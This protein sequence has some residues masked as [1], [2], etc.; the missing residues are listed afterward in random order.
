MA[1]AK[2]SEDVMNAL[3]ENTKVIDANTQVLVSMSEDKDKKETKE[4][5]V[6]PKKQVNSS[7][8]SDEKTRYANIGKELFAPVLK[9]LEKLLK[10]EKK[11]NEMTISNESETVEKA[12][13]VQYE[14]KPKEDN[15]KRTS[16]I[17]IL[18]GILAVAGIAV[19]MF[20]DKIV[21]FFDNAWSWIKDTFGTIAKFFDFSNP[22]NPISKIL[23]AIGT[24][25]SVTWDLVKKAFS[26]LGKLG[27]VIWDGIK[28]AW[29]K[30][31]TGPDGILNFGVKII[32]GIIDFAKSAVSWI[33]DAISS[34]IIDPLKNLFGGAED[35]GKSAGEE[36]A[37]DVKASVNQAAA[38]QAAKQKAITDDV[39]YNAQKA[40]AAIIE[41]A[42]AN[43]EDATKRAKE[44][45]LKLD[46]D[47]KVTDDSL[48]EAAA[49]SGLEAFMQAN[50]I[51]RSNID[52]KKYKALE[53][54]FKKHVQI[55]GNEA[56]INMEN[57]RNALK[58]R[59]DKEANFLAPD[60]PFINAL[61]DLDD[62]DGAEKMN[63]I[64]GAV[65]GALQKGLQISA[66]MQA[67]TNLENMSE[68]ERF[69]ARMRQAMAAGKSAEFRF[70]EGRSMILQSVET[71]KSAFAGYDETIRQNFTET[72]KS[73]MTDFIDHLKV[74]IS[75][76]S[77][78][79]N[80]KNTYHITPLNRES[81]KS[82]NDSMLK[83]A[84][85]NTKTIIAQNKIL[86]KIK[87]LLEEPPPQK[88]TIASQS[89]E[90]IKDAVEDGVNYVAKEGKRHLKELWGAV[91][92]WA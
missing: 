84:A 11:K 59:A 92:S 34:A 76:V 15:E 21:E 46:K 35:S 39:L 63:Q 74:E 52:D 56:K 4:K 22:N 72:W 48:R 55:N 79:D 81:F 23:S 66:D 85:I 69:E 5:N 87:V 9:S 38:D 8:T 36:A 77:P 37:K 1:E 73:F 42:K 60:G 41:T 25:I 64:N 80:S 89:A 27:S 88:I 17:P 51:D 61:Q 40:D 75:T 10:K 67:A 20:K 12:V 3:V 45:G 28:T 58:E 6:V 32:K 70:M 13:K 57:L 16:W 44:Q 78:Q 62:A 33:G 83:L 68:E 49:K 29:D 50:G 14:D 43:R 54:E 86:E 31:I 65:T 47:G 2:L 71:I 18:L 90:D 7:L 19:Y 91:S 26:A 30:F 24:G 53:D 82:M